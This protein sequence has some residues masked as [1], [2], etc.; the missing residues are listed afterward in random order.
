MSAAKEVWAGPTDADEDD[1]VG[2]LRRNARKFEKY[3]PSLFTS[4]FPVF[5]FVFKVVMIVEIVARP[6]AH[7]EAARLHLNSH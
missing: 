3:W 5:S 4:V 2:I 6:V 1:E 7:L